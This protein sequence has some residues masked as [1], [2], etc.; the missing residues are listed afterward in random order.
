MGEATARHI[1]AVTRRMAR[2]TAEGQALELGWRD[3]DRR[4]LTAA[5]Y[6]T[7][8]MKKTAWMSAIWPAQLGALI[9]GGGDVD[10]DRLVRFGFFLGTAFQI[11]D[12]LLN[13]VADTAYGKER[14]GDLYEAKRTLML[15]HALEVA[16]GDDRRALDA[17][18]GLGR[19]G[20]TPAMV[21]DI[22][23]RLDRLGSIAHARAV[24]S[25]L[26]GAALHE[27]GLAFG[28]LPPSRDKAFIAGL[29]P[30][31]FERT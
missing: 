28:H 16:S 21:A 26:A 24:A 11:Q 4:D 18:L 19:D 1:L 12:D 23:D 9:A 14:G 17:F 27:F 10:P 5:D 29:V 22:A 6:M 30:W 2:E 20:R 7:M 3:H 8:A 13:L 15:I 25:G 31:V